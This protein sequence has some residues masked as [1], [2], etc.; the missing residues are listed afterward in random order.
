MCRTG[1][2]DT[3][4]SGQRDPTGRRSRHAGAAP[5]DPDALAQGL[6]ATLADAR[7][8]RRLG[9]RGWELAQPYRVDRVVDQYLLF[10][11][12]LL[13]SKAACA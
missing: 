11:E 6:A 12:G 7:A 1:V 8:R 2:G 3:G 13:S 9:E 5:E 4:R 10:Y